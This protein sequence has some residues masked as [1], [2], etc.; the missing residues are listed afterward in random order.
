MERVPQQRCLSWPETEL[1]H[2][3]ILGQLLV[4]RAEVLQSEAKL[5]ECASEQVASYD[6]CVSQQ[7]RAKVVLDD[8]ERIRH[9]LKVYKSVLE[10]ISV[11][12][13]VST[14]EE[15]LDQRDQQVKEM[16][17]IITEPLD[18]LQEAFGLVDVVET[19][20]KAMEKNVSQIRTILDSQENADITQAEKLYHCEN[21]REEEKPE[22]LD[23]ISVSD[24][25]EEMQSLEN[26]GHR[27]FSQEVESK[28]HQGENCSEEPGNSISCVKPEL[29]DSIG[30]Q[31]TGPGS[32]KLGF[33]ADVCQ[34]FSF[35]TVMDDDIDDEHVTAAAAAQQE[36]SK[37]EIFD[38]KPQ[39]SSTV[40]EAVVGDTR[41]I[42]SRPITPFCTKKASD[43]LIEEEDKH[44]SLSSVNLSHQVPE[45]SS[46]PTGFASSVLRSQLS[47]L[48]YVF[49]HEP[50]ALKSQEDEWVHLEVRAK[51]LQQR[52]LE[53][54]VAS[55]KKLQDWIHWDHLCGQLGK[56]LDESEA[57]ISS[58]E[59]EG[60]DDKETVER[61]LHACKLDESRTVLGT[62]LDHRAVLQAEPWFGASVRQAG[63]ALE[64]RWKGA[65][66]RTEQE[67]LRLRNIQ[68]SRA[69]F[70]M[71][72][73]LQVLR[74]AVDNCQQVLDLMSQ[75][76]PKM[77]EAEVQAYRLERTTFAE[78]LGSIRLQ[79]LLLQRELDSQVSA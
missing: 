14:Q 28:G 12:C 62:L 15:R 73:I 23:I 32:P 53:E 39:I 13:D 59:P 71:P 78:N 38:I 69:R 16:Q 44:L 43:E 74:T 1:L 29:D 24:S 11:V 10:E 63:G 48:Q 76:G 70:F 22:N 55:Q 68:E 52:I 79:W 75:P 54:V 51:A 65:Y 40:V 64:L 61:R 49:Q 50:N 26:P 25:P 5:S 45:E 47:F 36:P 4:G 77:V 18:Q 30:S 8:S 35:E 6:E 72:L 60:D 46:V 19:D 20:I 34:T 57:F 41:L 66:R 67:V 42:P 27:R 3:N 17:Q 33:K 56:V 58:G 7:K 37:Q 2:I 9:T 31:N 21:K